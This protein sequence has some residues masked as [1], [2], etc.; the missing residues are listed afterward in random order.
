M[1]LSAMNIGWI[2]VFAPYLG[3]NSWSLTVE[4]PPA[5]WGAAQIALAEYSESLAQTAAAAY[6]THLR[7]RLPSNADQTEVIDSLPAAWHDNL[8]S[9][10]FQVFVVSGLAQASFTVFRWD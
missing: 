10:T 8:T 3:T 5:R 9:I 4:F 2:Q 7:H 6:I 1:P